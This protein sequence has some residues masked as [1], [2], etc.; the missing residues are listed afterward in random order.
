[1]DLTREN[2][3]LQLPSEQ[4]YVLHED[5]E[6]ITLFNE[7]QSS[8]RQLHLDSLPE[9]FIGNPKKA[10][11]VFLGLNPGHHQKDAEA[12]RDP[13]LK[14]ALLANLRG[15]LEEYPFYPFDPAL[16]WSPVATWWLKRTRELRS[17]TGL[18]DSIL[19][20]RIMAIEWFP[21]HSK[22][23]GL[24]K[25]QVCNSQSYT[26]RLVRELCKDRLVIRKGSREHWRRVDAALANVP[27][28]SSPQSGYITFRN[29]PPGVFQEIVDRLRS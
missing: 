15:E 7:P 5:K 17:A 16:D 6:Q 9:P 14:K 19:S 11:V 24:P 25:T 1:M 18:T 28:L 2:P 29:L 4:P 20:Q 13:R 10:R 26:F 8:N 23:S 22:S 3:W 12:H 21:Y 27:E